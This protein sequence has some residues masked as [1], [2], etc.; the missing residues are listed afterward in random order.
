MANDLPNDL[1]NDVNPLDLKR[2][3]PAAGATARSRGAVV[4]VG[5]LAASRGLLDVAVGIVG[6]P[7]GDLLI[8]VTPKG[9]ARVA[10]DIEPRDE[11]LEEIAAR[12]SP[13]ILESSVATQAWR[14]ELDE[15]FERGRTRFDLRVD[16][17][18]LGPFAREVL[19]GAAR[20]PFGRTTTYGELAQRIGHPRAARAVGTALGSNPIP[21]VLPCHRVLR[22]GGR[23]GG[24]G[25]GLE[26]KTI[27]LTL[28]GATS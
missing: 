6:S 2:L 7:I 17:R 8:A 16:R 1:P 23:L 9:L 4:S 21:V 13:R 19:A 24:Y 11:V 20:V 12:V 5:D 3:A 10:F 27:L 22:A 26:R 18:L 28:E 25:G 15:Y 14:R